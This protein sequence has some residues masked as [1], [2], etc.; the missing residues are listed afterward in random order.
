MWVPARGADTLDDTLDDGR[1]AVSALDGTHPARTPVRAT[2]TP[3]VIAVRRSV[4]EN[5]GFVV[6]MSVLS[7]RGHG[8][9]RRAGAVVEECFDETNPR[10]QAGLGQGCRHPGSGAP[11][12]R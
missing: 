10:R 6:V 5:A 1:A 11:G 3:A 4:D 8:V 9:E 12:R 7:V 2:A